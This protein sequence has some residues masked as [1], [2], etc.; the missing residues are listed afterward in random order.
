[1]CTEK[2]AKGY[3]FCIEDIFDSLYEP[4][5]YDFGP[6]NFGQIYLFC[7]AITEAVQVGES[8]FLPEAN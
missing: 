4:F 3:F 6:P 7:E 8:P 5:C 2:P 1:M